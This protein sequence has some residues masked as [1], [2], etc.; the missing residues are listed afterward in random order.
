MYTHT[1]ARAWHSVSFGLRGSSK[2]TTMWW[3]DSGNVWDSA[4]NTGG[5]PIATTTDAGTQILNFTR[6]NSTKTVYATLDL[7]FKWSPDWNGG[8]MASSPGGRRARFTG[9]DDIEQEV[10]DAAHHWWSN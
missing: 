9:I 7:S 5:E 4:G 1:R 8:D 10:A 3:C 6:D 2:G